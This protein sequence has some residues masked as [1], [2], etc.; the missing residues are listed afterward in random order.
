M[1][2]KNK[3]QTVLIT[4]CSSGFGK[5][6][7]RLFA[8]RGWNVIATMRNTEAGTDL[9]NLNN[10]LVTHLDVQDPGSIEAAVAKGIQTFGEI[11]VVVN[12]AGFGL[13]GMLEEVPQEKVQLQFET[14][15]FGPMN[16]MRSILPHFRAK[17]SGTIINVTSGLGI[18]SM[19]MGA[20]YTSSKF[21]MEGFSEAVSFELATVGVTVKIV[22]PGS[23]P[24][25]SFGNRSRSEAAGPA[26]PIPD[27]DAIR[28]HGGE[29][30]KMF[31]A[32]VVENA[33]EKV[34]QTIYTA[35]TDGT[36]QLRYLATDDIKPFVDARRNL[37]EKDY[38]SFLRSHYLPE[39]DSGKS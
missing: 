11:D 27:Y 17:H 20:F 16:V 39:K 32:N 19:P 6:T 31:R 36:D 4:G 33:V 18:F 25:T 3:L 2:S 23:A 14:N 13:I 10:V 8:A 37:S 7:A 9:G 12:N 38:I 30:V 34:A 29:V 21:A 35:A 1:E 26:N 28:A 5:E 22:E 24:E 15:V